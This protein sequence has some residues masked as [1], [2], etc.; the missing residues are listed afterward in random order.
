MRKRL[1][2][3][4]LMDD[5]LLP[6]RGFFR[7]CIMLRRAFCTDTL[8]S[9]QC[10]ATVSFFR[11]RIITDLRFRNEQLLEK[12]GLDGTQYMPQKPMQIKPTICHGNLK[13]NRNHQMRSN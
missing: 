3:L 2:R 9:C 5:R 4:R 1:D 13:P 10:I 7:Q 8:I 12:I 6:D 11:Q